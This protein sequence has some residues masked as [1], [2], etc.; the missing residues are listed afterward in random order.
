LQEHSPD[1][2]R[3][4]V[5]FAARQ[6][7]EI[8]MD[9]YEEDLVESL[10]AT[11]ITCLVLAS[12]THLFDMISDDPTIRSEAHQRLVQCKA[13]FHAFS[14]QQFGGAWAL[15]VI[16]Y[17]SNRLNR[18][19]IN[20]SKDLSASNSPRIS[21]AGRNIADI[22][23]NTT[24]S[25]AIDQPDHLQ[26]IHS[27]SWTASSAQQRSTTDPVNDSSGTSKLLASEIPNIPASW[28]PCQPFG[29]TDAMSP[30]LALDQPIPDSM[31]DF[32]GPD[33][34]WLD[35]PDASETMNG[36]SWAGVGGPA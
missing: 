22:G 32:L 7:T 35:F 26:T 9:F 25:G 8:A 3:A 24:L 31:V 13:I 33:L 23:G 12:I 21:A 36:T 28:M 15:H 29:T 1:P 5:R 6:I 14:E 10:G 34:A 16:E 19:R 11:S 18:D 4:M 20:N 17:I 2:S 27:Q 30:L